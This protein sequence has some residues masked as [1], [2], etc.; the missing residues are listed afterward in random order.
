MPAADFTLAADMP[1]AER[2]AQDKKLIEQWLVEGLPAADTL[3]ANLHAAMHY[4]V[5]NGGK[6]FR[7]ILTL[8]VGR[9]LGLPRA[10][11][12]A[13]A[14]ALEYLHSY[15]LVHD[16]LPAMDDDDWRRGQPTCHKVFGEA[17]AILA[18]DALQ[19]LAFATLAKPQPEVSAVAQLAMMQVLAEAAG[20]LGMA[21]GQ[22]MDITAVAKNLSS[23]ELQAMHQRKTGAL[24]KA[25]V[26]MPLIV[27]AVE[28]SE[29]GKT[30][31][32][33]AEILGLA[34]QIQ[35]DILDVVGSQEELG[36]SPG[37]DAKQD[38]P[39][40]VSVLGLAAAQAQL[41]ECQQ[42]VAALLAPF[43]ETAPLQALFDYVLTRRR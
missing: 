38:K 15:S 27:A 7:P 1:L 30:L 36:K 29:L 10:Q 11:L 3:P 14:C 8:S 33:Y 43:P 4:S 13:P 42:Q 40:Y 25:A 17:M 21:G 37:S 6:R 32:Q 22:A 23:A 24:I 41:T 31:R 2:L 16:D 39:T 20:S 12:R 26:V 34:F 18:G 9:C 5:M 19:T 35:D 28:H